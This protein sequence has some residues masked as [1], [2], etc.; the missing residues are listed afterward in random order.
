MK[1]GLVKEASAGIVLPEFFEFENGNFPISSNCPEF[2][3]MHK[4]LSS[5]EYV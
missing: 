2:Y 1:K 5:F 4:I 3:A